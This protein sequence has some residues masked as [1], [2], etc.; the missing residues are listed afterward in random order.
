MVNLTVRN[1]PDYIMDKIRIL[2]NLERRSVN[3][4]ILCILE[5]GLED[6]IRKNALLA[7]NISKGTQISIWKNLAGKWKDKRSTKVII[8]DIMDARTGGRE[9][10]L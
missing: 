4:E 9:I 1:I 8:K 10:N 2:S 3:N 6:E 7:N 5:K